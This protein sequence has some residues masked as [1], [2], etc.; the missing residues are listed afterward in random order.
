MNLVP[1]VIEQTGRGERAYDIFSRLLSDR[2]VILG[3]PIND[4]DGQPDHRRSCCSSSP[5]TLRRDIYFYI[6]SPGGSV[7]AGLA[8]YD[9]MQ[10]ITP[11][12]LDSVYGTGGEHGGV[13]AARRGRRASATRCRTPGS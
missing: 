3:A 4:D 11:R 13:A 10:Y 7:T 1:I 9:T 8:I 2:I 5:R 12:G 6:N